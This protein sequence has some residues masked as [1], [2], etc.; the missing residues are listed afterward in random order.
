MG[1]NLDCFKE[2]KLHE[3]VMIIHESAGV[4]KPEAAFVDED[5]DFDK[6][7]AVMVIFEYGFFSLT[8][9]VM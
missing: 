7:I 4:T 6:Y 5:K 1:W 2:R 3:V 9:E 8:R